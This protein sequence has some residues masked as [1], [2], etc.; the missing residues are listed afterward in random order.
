MRECLGCGEIHVEVN[1]P[2]VWCHELCH[3]DREI[4]RHE[5]S[6]QQPHERPSSLEQSPPVPSA[7]SR[8]S[9]RPIARPSQSPV[10]GGWDR[11]LTSQ[12]GNGA[13]RSG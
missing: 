12:D 1:T 8:D 5:E 2:C 9:A 4:V 10:I 7:H 11:S 6:D 3:S 13:D